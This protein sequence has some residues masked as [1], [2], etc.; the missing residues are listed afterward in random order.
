MKNNEKLSY[1]RRLAHNTV[2]ALKVC[3][4]LIKMIYSSIRCDDNNVVTVH[5]EC[6]QFKNA[7]KE[8]LCIQVDCWICWEER[9]PKKDRTTKLLVRWRVHN[10][11]CALKLFLSLMRNHWKRWRINALGFDFVK[12]N[13]QREKQKK[14]DNGSMWSAVKE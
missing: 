8:Q 2:Y 10:I 3:W 6:F 11:D 4:S 7:L 1:W 13:E 9:M 12:T 14:Y 5:L